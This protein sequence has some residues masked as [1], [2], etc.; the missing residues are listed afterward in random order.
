MDDRELLRKYF[1]DH[2]EDAFSE[3]IRRHVNLV[4]TTALRLVGQPDMAQD[5]TQAMQR[6]SE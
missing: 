5:V 6:K 3:L 4:Y 1:E 2:A